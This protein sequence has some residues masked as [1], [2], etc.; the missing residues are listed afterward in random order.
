VGHSVKSF[1]S[2]R[3]PEKRGG[4]WEALQSGCIHSRD[5]KEDLT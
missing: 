3:L 1:F 4:L 5:G 2:K